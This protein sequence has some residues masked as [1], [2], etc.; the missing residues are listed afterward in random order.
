M[1]S[2][3]TVARARGW[4]T[5]LIRPLGTA[6]TEE[7]EHRPALGLDLR[8]TPVGHFVKAPEQLEP[9][10]S[11]RVVGSVVYREVIGRPIHAQCRAGRSAEQGG[12]DLQHEV[13]EHSLF[14]AVT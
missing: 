7:V 3:A 10:R 4:T 11:V 2:A 8:E 1:T 14:S 6:I 9:H 5:S 12:A 13:D